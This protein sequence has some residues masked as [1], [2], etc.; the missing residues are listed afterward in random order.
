MEAVFQPFSDVTA[1]R[2]D[3]IAEHG[4]GITAEICLP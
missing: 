3:P 1:D 2:N 4:P